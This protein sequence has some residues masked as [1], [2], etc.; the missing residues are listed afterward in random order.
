MFLRLPQ[1]QEA[2]LL[3]AVAQYLEAQSELP[4]LTT[5][6]APMTLGPLKT[7]ACLVPLLAATQEW[8]PQRKSS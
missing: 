4:R 3:Q 6:A 7:Q 8:N 5:T 1:C 2:Q